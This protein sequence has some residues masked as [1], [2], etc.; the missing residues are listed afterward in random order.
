MACSVAAR[1]ADELIDLLINILDTEVLKSLITEDGAWEAFVKAAVLSREEEAALHD[2]LKKHLAQ[3]PT[4]KNERLEKALQKKRFLEE[5]PQLKRKL[6]GHIRELRDLANYLDKVHKDCTISNV[7]SSSTGTV[8]GVLDILGFVLAPFTGGSSLMLTAASLGLGA[9]ASVTSLTTTIVEDTILLKTGAEAKR[10]VGV[11]K[12]IV[13]EMGKIV[14]KF[15]VKLISTG[16]D[17]VSAWKTLGQQIQHFRVARDSF[18]S[19]T[20]ARNLRN[21]TAFE[22]VGNAFPNSYLTMTRGARIRSV[23]LS[24]L[25][26]ALDLYHLVTDSKDL[27]KGAITESGEALRS[28]AHL[29][30]EKLQEFELIQKALQSDLCQ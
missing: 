24:S 16:V 25:F 9:A 8:S 10:L 1:A 15:A 26:L 18:R 2:A 6:E 29:L 20:Q 19:G 17:L 3:E 13:K 11:S 14:P 27:S 7:V 5:F 12:S 21:S 28:L 30:E 23:G 22:Q 4:D